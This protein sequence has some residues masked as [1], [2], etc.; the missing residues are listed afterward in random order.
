VLAEAMAA[1]DLIGTFPSLRA[2]Q[3]HAWHAML[4]QLGALA[5]LALG[6]AE[7]PV[8]EEGWRNGLRA[9]TPE[10]SH[11][12]PWSLVTPPGSPALLQPPLPR[13]EMS[14]LRNRITTPDELD[15]LVTARNHDL[16]QSVMA[17][18]PMR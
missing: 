12:A 2:H 18:S 16:K 13:G 4:A 6:A 10:H 14:A 1:A 8:T 9:L 5:T 11:D 17:D 15:M 3:R 7:P